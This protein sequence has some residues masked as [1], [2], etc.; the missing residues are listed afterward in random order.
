MLTPGNL[1]AVDVTAFTSGT[2]TD[3]WVSTAD[4]SGA[5]AWEAPGGRV[6]D[7]G[8]PSDIDDTADPGAGTTVAHANHVHRLQT[9]T[10]V[11]FTAAGVLGTT[12]SGGGGSGTGGGGYSAWG[13]IG[14]ITGAISGIADNSRAGCQSGHR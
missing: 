12:G 1:A 5:V 9:D 10:S 3:G 8:N 11:E 6:F 2:A 7:T 4:G 13:D 14:S